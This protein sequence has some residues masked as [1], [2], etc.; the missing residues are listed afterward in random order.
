MPS[1][2]KESAALYRGERKSVAK[3]TELVTALGSSLC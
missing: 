3:T 1:G 2:G